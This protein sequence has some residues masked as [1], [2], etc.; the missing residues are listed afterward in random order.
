MALKNFYLEHI[1]PIYK[2]KKRVGVGFI[3][4]EIDENYIILTCK[5]VIYDDSGDLKEELSIGERFLNSS[6]VDVIDG[7]DLALLT[8]DRVKN[9]KITFLQK[10]VQDEFLTIST[11]QNIN[12]D[13]NSFIH[14]NIDT[15]IEL[16]TS[17]TYHDVDCDAYKIRVQ[18]P[19]EHGYSGSPIFDK[20][21]GHAIAILSIKEGE[22]I[23]YA[24]AIENIKRFDKDINVVKLD[25]NT[26]LG[27]IE[28]IVSVV[29]EGAKS[30]CRIT[31]NQQELFD[32]QLVDLDERQ[33]DIIEEIKSYCHESEVF[34]NKIELIISDD[35]FGENIGLWKV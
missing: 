16:D 13:K 21:T 19:L 25:D 2:N 5:H 30:N 8:I 18:D 4:D 10:K 24:I 32:N 31:I 20:N 33:L 34:I 14:K 1:V 7:I 11:Y 12:D 28:D 27:S 6:S 26:N 29:F 35:L 22:N 15:T 17:L 3:V 9:K 23:G